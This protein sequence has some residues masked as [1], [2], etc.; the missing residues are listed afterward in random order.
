MA[1]RSRRVRLVT[2]DEL[3]LHAYRNRLLPIFAP[4]VLDYLAI[5]LSFDEPRPVKQIEHASA[6]H[7]D[8]ASFSHAL[9]VLVYRGYLI[10]HQRADRRLR[11]FSLRDVLEN[12]AYSSSPAS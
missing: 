4:R 8:R 2:R 11:C 10:E 7:I 6:A 1:G 12:A 5:Q 9:D 3:V